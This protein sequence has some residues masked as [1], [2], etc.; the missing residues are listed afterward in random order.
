MPDLVTL[1]ID[2]KQVTVPAG[3]LVV[4]A[5]RAAGIE[6]PIFC[7]HRKL[8]PLGACR[9]CLVEFV[10]PRGSRLDTS[11]TVRVSEGMV[12]RTD[13]D[14]VKAVREANLAFILI[15]HPLDC[16][17]CDKGGECPLQDQTMEYGPGFSRFIEPK[18]HKQKHYPI[19]DLIMLDQERCILCWR[20]IRYLEEWED[21]P[22]IGLFK[23]G[24]ETLID[25]FPDKPVDAKTSGSIID[26]C[27]VGA[28]T[29]RVARFRY[30]PWEL[31]MTPSICTLCP[32]G[33]NLRL[34]ERVHELRR[35]VAREN[36]AVNDEWICDKGRFLYQ[37]VDHPGRLTQPLIRIDGE[38]RTATW[39]EALDQIV[40][41]L[42][43][44]MGSCGAQ[45]IGGIASGR[46]S[47]EGAYLFQKFFRALLGSN[48]VDFPDGSAAQG[49][50]TAN[51]LPAISDIAKSDLIVLIG[52]DPSEA[53]PIL[54]LHIKRAIFRAGARLLII[55]S[56]R[57]E[58][59]RYTSDLRVKT[60]AYLAVRPGGEADVLNGLAAAILAQ[61][62]A[63]RT[64]PAPRERGA[65][66]HRTRH[67]SL[68]GAS[69]GPMTVA[70]LR[71]SSA[72]MKTPP[73]DLAAAA[74]LLAEAKTPLFLYGS[75][76]AMGERGSA[77]VAALS[78]LA[79]LLGHGDKLA[80]VGLEGN[81]QG[82]RDMGLLPD[83]L[84][85]HQPI[86]DAAARSRLGKLWGVEPPAE[87][88]LS[89][90]QMLEGGVRALYVM[91][92]DPGADPALAETLRGLDFLVV[93][94]LFLSDTARLADVVL[95]A[96]SFAEGDGTYT[97][98]ERRVQRAP[99]GIRAFGESR[100]DWAIVTALA[101][102]WLA[103]RVLDTAEPAE[104]SGMPEWKK[105]RRKRSPAGWAGGQRGSVPRPW[106]YPNARTV[107][108]EIGQA[109]A[110]YAGLSW[111]TLGTQG[112]QSK[113][114]VRGRQ[115]S[116]G[117]VHG[118]AQAAPTPP[119]AIV[120]PPDGSFWLVSGPLLW[121][122]DL[123]MQY[124]PE[125]IRRLIPEPFVALNPADLGAAAVPRGSRVL[126][127]SSRG[128]ASLIVRA[129]V[130][131]QPGT[132]W[133]P[134]KL[135]GLPAE[136][137]GAGRGEPVAVT[138]D[139]SSVEDPRQRAESSAP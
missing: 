96:T 26:I 97:N 135:A 94:D 19:S 131:V 126:V 136:T 98:L 56:R 99:Q 82:A 45:G 13:T 1:T 114:L 42:E 16:P 80:Y 90:R 86:G 77:A 68:P 107:L 101:Q 21:K 55:N 134:A 95:P 127:R 58:L 37:Y 78:N 129:D 39:D 23:R 132:A 22:Q 130:S 100:P 116:T 89:Y 83:R 91:G 113:I 81:S 40:E 74:T 73:A 49:D 50:A 43:A 138:L 41:Y 18:R 125:E 30:R 85:G 103:A 108:E 35:I 75:D 60:G 122:A 121:N 133:I 27:P 106:T 59:A 71:G 53:T 8:D 84:P 32:V 111:E 112:A 69:E 124:G 128:T 5:A 47:N 93:Q 117:A 12:V 105:K 38:L 120:A 72:A 118:S 31:K 48:N 7:S 57:I 92:A 54:D 119:A 4:D 44:A 6:I 9:M 51:G 137:L 70:P 61:K 25:V 11:C 67:T 104:L 2:D 139:P 109:V 76:A 34:D 14:Q 65:A 36:M 115:A 63:G 88:G 10:G 87:P 28:L 64:P 66:G 123:L 52:F 29:N 24:N 17:I 33:C 46:V 62:E 15:N 79:L 3:T 20:C 102:C 110:P